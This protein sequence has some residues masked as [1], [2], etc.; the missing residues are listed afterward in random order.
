MTEA[1]KIV[2]AHVHDVIKKD[3]VKFG[4]VSEWC[5]KEGCWDSLRQEKEKIRSELPDSFLDS[6]VSEEDQQSAETTARKFQK[7]DNGIEAQRRVMEVSSA[8][9]TDIKH[10]LRKANR[11]GVKEEKLLR[12]AMAIPKMIPT[13]KQ[14]L[15]L[16]EVLEQARSEGLLPIS[17]R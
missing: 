14:S 16:L 12:V 17:L 11:L 3:G 6:L 13:E 15:S 1:I 2:A 8:A 10:A 9:W 4:N 7:M 5:K